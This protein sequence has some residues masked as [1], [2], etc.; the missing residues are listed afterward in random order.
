MGTER[1]PWKI[2]PGDPSRPGVTG[3][4]NRYNFAVDTRTGESPELLFY[5]DGR[6]EQRILLDDRMLPTGK[7]RALDEAEQKLRS[8]EGQSPLY[9]DLDDHFTAEPILVDGKLF[10]G[11]ILTSADR[12]ILYEVDPSYRHW[13]LFNAHSA[14]NL[15]C[16][17]PQNWRINA[18]N[19]PLP[20]E[21][22]GLDI[23]APGENVSYYSRIRME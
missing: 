12:R 5:R 15:I 20:N 18:P 4:G 17:E 3:K 1:K 16:I 9:K 22:S 2:S 21:V 11:A 13:M 6:E 7:V 14:G 19:L 23:L 10:H 8:D